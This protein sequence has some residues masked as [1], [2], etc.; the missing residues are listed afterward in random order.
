MSDPKISL[1]IL[2]PS[3]A[4]ASALSLDATGKSSSSVALSDDVSVE[5][6]PAFSTSGFGSSE[7]LVQA[8]ITVGSGVAV[9]LLSSL[10]VSWLKKSP[11]PPK[12]QIGAIHVETLD[13]AS[14]EDAIA[15]AIAD[16]TTS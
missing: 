8:A 14:L 4:A 5:A 6:Q 12:I 11:D 3:E 10:L 2:C 13:A 7:L 16:A 9:N 1:N 15:K